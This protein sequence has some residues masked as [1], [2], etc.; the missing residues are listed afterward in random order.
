MRTFDSDDDGYLFWVDANPDGFV[1]N[2]SR[3]PRPNYL[4]LHR[5]ACKSIPRTAPEPIRWTS[6]DYIKT[7]SVDIG[8]LERWARDV[9]GGTLSPCGMCEPI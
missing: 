2:S 9:T 1:V 3:K 5:A 8:E 7:C 6:G 4:I